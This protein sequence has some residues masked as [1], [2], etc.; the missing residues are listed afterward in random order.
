MPWHVAKTSKCSASKPWGVIKDADGKVVGCHPTEDKAKDQLK[1]LYANEPK[2]K[3][4]TVAE[5]RIRLRLMD[6]RGIIQGLGPDK[7]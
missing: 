1:A 6:A 5:V 4:M 2:A 3:A 7:L